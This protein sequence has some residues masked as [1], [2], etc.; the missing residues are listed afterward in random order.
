MQVTSTAKAVHVSQSVSSSDCQF[1]LCLPPA[2]LSGA[3]VDAAPSASWLVTWSQTTSSDG[4]GGGGG[5]MV[6]VTK[7]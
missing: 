2:G 5:G 4:G 6:S 1:Y 7:T 3:G